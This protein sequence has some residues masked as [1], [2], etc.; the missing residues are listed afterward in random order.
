MHDQIGIAADG[1]REMGILGQVQAEMADIG[2]IIDR[3]RLG[4]QHHVI[5]DFFVHAALGARQNAVEGAGL[6]H[7]GPW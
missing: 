1:R 7:L 5:H 2:G 4:A 3:L 6:H